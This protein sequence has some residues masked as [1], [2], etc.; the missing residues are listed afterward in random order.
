MIDKN[1]LYPISE[2][3]EKAG[4]PVFIRRATYDIDFFVEITS[5]SDGVAYGDG[6]RGTRPIGRRY[7]YEVYKHAYFC[8]WRDLKECEELAED[9]DRNT[10]YTLPKREDGRFHEYHDITLP[11]YIPG[12]TI[13]PVKRG[14]E[15]VNAVFTGFEK[16]EEAV[17][18]YTFYQGREAFC[19]F[20]GNLI[21]E[22][23][24]LDETE[25][26]TRFAYDRLRSR[27]TSRE[28]IFEYLTN[29]RGVQVLVHFTPIENL[30]SI[31][32]N[33]IAPRKYFLDDGDDIVVTDSIRMDNRLECSCFT[34]SFPNYQM[35][36]IKRRETGYRFA[37]LL[38]DI[39]ALLSSCVDQVYYL[40]VNAAYNE[41]RQRITTF[42]QLQDAKNMFADELMYK[43]IIYHRNELAIPREYT[44]SPQAE[45]MIDGIVPAH[46]I[47][48]VCFK[49]QWSMLAAGK[50]VKKM[51]SS[52]EVR[53]EPTLFLQR[54]DGEYWQRG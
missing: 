17:L 22:P 35:L 32:E 29:E 34:L 36:Y 5:V 24:P 30:N 11:P 38:V 42:N 23:V 19:R 52:T 43:G 39:K 45:V 3:I 10:P 41:V 1:V 33:G 4:L 25:P 49:D 18:A 46:Y 16:R 50:M 9:S 37:V 48:A 14:G 44:T 28:D 6:F 2:I 7:S 12:K 15:W 27:S 53:V 51:P 54:R 26:A 20:G 47:K 31:F 21:R 13:L 8:E 40:P